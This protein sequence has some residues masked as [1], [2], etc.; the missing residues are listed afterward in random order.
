MGRIDNLENFLTDVATSIRN[1]KNT[2]D[3]I[4]P[5][6][7]SDEIDGIIVNEGLNINGQIYSSVVSMNEFISKGDYVKKEYNGPK[8]SNTIKLDSIGTTTGVNIGRIISIVTFEGKALVFFIYKK[9]LYVKILKVLNNEVITEQTIK[10]TYTGQNSY[11]VSAMVLDSKILV[12]YENQ[13]SN[14][15]TYPYIMICE[16][17]N[18]NF[19]VKVTYK[20]DTTNLYIN[21]IFLTTIIGTDKILLLYEGFNDHYKYAK[22]CTV[23]D[24]NT[25]FLNNLTMIC[26]DDYNIVSI[27]PIENNKVFATSY[28]VGSDILFGN[29]INV[30][31]DNVVM[32]QNVS[33]IKS[34]THSY[35]TEFNYLF[36]EDMFNISCGMVNR[37]SIGQNYLYGFSF[38]INEQYPIADNSI[39]IVSQDLAD[40]KWTT[41]K[42]DKNSISVFYWF[43][44]DIYSR[45]IIFVDNAIV[46][47]N[48]TLLSTNNYTFED[49]IKS[50]QLEDN[51]ILT[52][53]HDGN[54]TYA[55]L[56]Y[57]F[58]SISK[59]NLLTDTVFGIANSSGNGGDTID[60]IIPI[61]Q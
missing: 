2:K 32:E 5:K 13:E 58:F 4:L 31:E 20:L 37:D 60:V 7:F 26:G 24:D 47:K 61:A 53:F 52:I 12:L 56:V 23:L 9:Y 28:T 16:Y 43:N 41:Q 49:A 46:V 48:Y 22:I 14:N 39:L 54:M 18:G 10:L 25:V 44:R 42:I 6:N 50:V 29:I 17:L 38:N 55:T 40:D 11:K 35:S 30:S 19:T 36:N 8:A 1:K 15:Y 21:G 3:K 34:Y 57:N 51:K 27:I 33:E 59:A 45:S